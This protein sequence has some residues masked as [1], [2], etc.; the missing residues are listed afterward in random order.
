MAY[1]RGWAYKLRQRPI[2]SICPTRLC[3]RGSLNKKGCIYAAVKHFLPLIAVVTV[4]A[5]IFAY[6]TDWKETLPSR[7]LGDCQRPWRT[8]WRRPRLYLSGDLLLALG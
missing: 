5:A 4:F 2:G 6:F 7:V 8:P 3:M 1:H